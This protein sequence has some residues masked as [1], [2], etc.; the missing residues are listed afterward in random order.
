MG[1]PGR[2]VAWLLPKPLQDPDKDPEE[3]VMPQQPELDVPEV[4]PG[5]E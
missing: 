4:G 1:R 5:T 3:E 2:W